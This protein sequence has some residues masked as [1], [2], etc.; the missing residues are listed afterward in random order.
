MLLSTLTAAA[1]MSIPSWVRA[2]ALATHML[3][4]FGGLAAGSAAWGAIAS[5]VGLRQ[6][7]ALAALVIVLGRAACW[8]RV[9]PEGSG[10]DLA[11]APRWPDPQIVRSFESGRGPALV[12]VE[13]QIDSADVE[14]ICA[15]HARPP[16]DSTA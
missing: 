13:Y 6:T 12:T 3:V 5:A 7:F 11:P 1:Q 9:L 10:P 4:L 8:R 15:C 14:S 16:L 2:R